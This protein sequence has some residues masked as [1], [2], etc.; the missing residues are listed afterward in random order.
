M[1]VFVFV[2]GF[3]FYSGYTTPVN[4]SSPMIFAPSTGANT[5][6]L[7]SLLKQMNWTKSMYDLKLKGPTKW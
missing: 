4:L 2:F 6:L 7:L 5:K 1:A 3:L